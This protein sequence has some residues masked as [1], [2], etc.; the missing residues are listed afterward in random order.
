[1]RRRVT[2][3]VLIFLNI[4][5]ASPWDIPWT[6]IPL[7][8]RISSPAAGSGYWLD[9]LTISP[10]LT[11]SQRSLLRGLTHREDGLDKDPHGASGRVDPTHHT[12]P[13]ALLPR[14]LFKFDIVNRNGLK[15][16][17]SRNLAQL[18]C[19]RFDYTIVVVVAV[20]VIVVVVVAAVLVVVVVVVVFVVVIFVVVIVISASIVVVFATPLL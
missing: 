4:D 19:H 3:P 16:M 20:V 12:E 13:Q 8:E 18:M 11:F 7:T 1:M 15:L 6:D 5:I 2:G 9:H 14:P 10:P 17:P